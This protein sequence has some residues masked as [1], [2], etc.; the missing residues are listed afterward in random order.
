MKRFQFL[1]EFSHS[2]LRRWYFIT[3]LLHNLVMT[4]LFLLLF[5]I[6]GG[7]P[8]KGKGLSFEK[9]VNVQH[10]LYSSGF[11]VGSELSKHFRYVDCTAQLLIL[12]FSAWLSGNYFLLI[13]FFAY[14]TVLSCTQRFWCDVSRWVVLGI[15]CFRECVLFRTG[16]C[17]LSTS[18]YLQGAK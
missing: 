13:W 1:L 8:S 3:R 5:Q 18:V 12:I 6:E 10:S 16:L 17:W 11:D 7:G 15:H 4:L 9:L 2:C 14:K